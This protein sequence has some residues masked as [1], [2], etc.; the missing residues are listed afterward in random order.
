MGQDEAAVA[1]EEHEV[2]TLFEVQACEVPV[3][4]MQAPPPVVPP[5]PEPLPPPEPPPLPLPLPLQL[6]VPPEL[7]P[8]V[9]L[10]CIVQAVQVLDCSAIEHADD[11]MQVVALQAL[12]VPPGQRQL[13]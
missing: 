5:L 8:L 12:N 11:G 1:P 2:V 13:K 9:V 3:P 4:V 10:H 7:L 6:V